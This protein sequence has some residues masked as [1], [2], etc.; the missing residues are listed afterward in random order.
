MPN[1]RPFGFLTIAGLVALGGAAFSIIGAYADG[2]GYLLDLIGQFA[3]QAAFAALALTVFFALL[4]RPALAG[5]SAAIAIAGYFVVSVPAPV[6]PCSG[7]PTHRVLFFNVWDENRHPTETVDFVAHQNADT[8][9]LAEVNPRFRPALGELRKLYPYFIECPN[10][11]KEGR[12]QFYVYS[13]VPI[14]RDA[15]ERSS[16]MLGFTAAY[17]EATINIAAIHALRPF[18]PHRHWYQFW[19]VSYFARLIAKSPQPRLIVGD[20]NAAN[21]SSIIR[22]ISKITHVKPLPS[23]GT[24]FALMPWPLRIPIDQALVGKGIMCAK[25][26]VGPAAFSDHRPIWVDF[27]LKSDAR[28]TLP[29]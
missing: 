2:L 28:A 13:R 15:G 10:H 18:P 5:L 4:R 8:V 11:E 9:V 16:A 14:D 24:W 22:T 12:C 27:A 23:R 25:K 29:R 21:W 26:T 20:F 6:A 19:Q 7:V 17:A 1:Y 3:I